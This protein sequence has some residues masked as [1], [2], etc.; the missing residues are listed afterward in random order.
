VF[1]ALAARYGGTAYA[2][3]HV[4]R[5][6]LARTEVDRLVVVTRR[7]SI[8]D[9]GLR[10]AEGLSVVRCEEPSG[11]ELPRRLAW[12][13]AR[14]PEVARRHGADGVFSFSGM[15]PRRPPCPV[16]S[17]LANPVPFEDRR[18]LG[19][20]LRR[21]A[22]GATSRH[23]RAVYVPSS[24][25][26]RLVGPGEN[27]HVVPLGVDRTSFRP[28]GGSGTELL[29]VADF[30]R[31][32]RHDVLLDAYGRLARPRPVLRLIGNPEVDP[33]NFERIRARA[34][35]IDGVEVDGRVALKDLLAAY[36]NARIFLMA[37]ARESFS[38]P[39]A[40]ALCCGVPA[41]ALRHPT[42]CETGGPGALYVD[43]HDPADWGAAIERLV[44]DDS[45]RSKVREAGLQHSRRYSWDAMAE[46]IVRDL[47][48][49]G[50]AA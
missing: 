30:Y 35:R 11:L 29:C 41:V 42:L 47:R 10:P 6:L 9:S 44:G 32:K 46:H 12:E 13:V 43:G 14:L 37:S 19:S 45:L 22:I 27:I 34:A 16:I 50:Q 39:L 4:A 2:V 17:L 24:H 7:G 49:A 33:E 38:M 8:V 15:V 18:R 31:H 36:A 48:L 28:H 5:S 21:A 23:A 20:A 40:E 26:E 1:D 25:V 3:V